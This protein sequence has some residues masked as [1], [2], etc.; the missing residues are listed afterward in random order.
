MDAACPFILFTVRYLLY[1]VKHLYLDR[2]S[3][4]GKTSKFFKTLYVFVTLQTLYVLCI[5]MHKEI[6]KRHQQ[7]NYSSFCKGVCPTC[8]NSCMLTY[9]AVSCWPMIQFCFFSKLAIRTFTACALSSEF[10]TGNISKTAHLAPYV[11]DESENSYMLL[12]SA[13]PLSITSNNNY[14]KFT[15][16]CCTVQLGSKSYCI[17]FFL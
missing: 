13:S 5:S 8:C 15:A 12:S 2:L 10:W 1:N 3:F 9:T 17:L 6:A 14:L 4:L 11:D 7:K 16:H